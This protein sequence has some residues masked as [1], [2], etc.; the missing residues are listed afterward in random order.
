MFFWKFK[1]TISFL[2]NLDITEMA[3]LLKNAFQAGLRL[4]ANKQVGF[5]KK[6][7]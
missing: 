6:T 5:T 2:L 3:F 4:G 1:T 7:N